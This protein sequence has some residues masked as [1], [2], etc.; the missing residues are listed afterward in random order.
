MFVLQWRSK[1][2]EQVQNSI[3]NNCAIPKAQRA[4][5][6]QQGKPGSKSKAKAKAQSKDKTKKAHVKSRS[7]RQPR[8]LDSSSTEDEDLAEAEG[9]SDEVHYSLVY[10]H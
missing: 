2:A 4:L 3:L 1:A 9:E 6:K 8:D 10:M 5:S 7:K